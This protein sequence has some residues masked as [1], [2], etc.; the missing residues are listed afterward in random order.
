V[1][2]NEPTLATVWPIFAKIALVPFLTG[3]AFLAYAIECRP[4]ENYATIA[5]G[6]MLVWIAAVILVTP[7]IIITVYFSVIFL[8]WF[9]LFVSADD[10]PGIG[11]LKHMRTAVRTM[12]ILAC[13]TGMGIAVPRLF[14][15]PTWEALRDTALA[16]IVFPA[17]VILSLFISR[18]EERANRAEDMM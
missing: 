10:I 18:F 16:G 7:P 15:A 6:I 17:G 14:A 4:A 8:I 13:L 11:W 1:P 5:F 2:D 3:I 9:L 12:I